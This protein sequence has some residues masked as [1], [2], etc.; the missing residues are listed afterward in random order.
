VVRADA[1][2][3][4]AEGLTSGEAGELVGVEGHEGPD[5]IGTGPGVLLPM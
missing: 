5:G 3:R 4:G 1:G 2:I